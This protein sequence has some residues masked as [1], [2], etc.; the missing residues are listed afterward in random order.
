MYVI[1]WDIIWNTLYINDANA[2][3]EYPDFLKPMF[4]DKLVLTYPNDDDAVLF[5]FNLMWVSQIWWYNR[6][7]LTQEIKSTT[8]RIPLVRSLACSE[9]SLGSRDRNSSHR[10]PQLQRHLHSNFHLLYRP[11]AFHAPRNIAPCPRAIRFMA[12][13]RRYPQERP[14]SRSSQASP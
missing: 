7:I 1:G 5:Q 12:A 10:N 6:H 9:P 4:K 2:P 14:S 3:K 11:P 8:I 13:D